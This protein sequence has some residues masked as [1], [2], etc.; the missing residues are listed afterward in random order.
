MLLAAEIG[1]LGQDNVDAGCANA[2]YGLDGA[3]DLAFKGADAGDLLHEGRQ[4]ERTDIVEQ[5]VAGVGTGGQTLFGKQHT[6]IGS[7]ADG[8]HHR[9]A[10]R[11]DVEG[12]AC[13]AERDADLVHVGALK[14]DIERLIGGT[15]EIDRA[16]ADDRKYQSRHAGHDAELAGTEVLQVRDNCLK[17]L[18][19]DPTAPAC[20][21]AGT[22]EAEACAK[23]KSGRAL[24]ERGLI[25]W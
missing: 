24:K 18:R 7:L 9:S 12:N 5:F 11:T 17:L 1:A 13:F 19:H 10:V 20:L 21:S 4:A 3:G 8:N 6:R 25:I 22:V 23:M 2:V 16:D 15:V 14:S